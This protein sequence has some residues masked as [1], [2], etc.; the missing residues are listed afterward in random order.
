MDHPT[1]DYRTKALH[2]VGR[3]IIPALSGDYHAENLWALQDCEP[4]SFRFASLPDSNPA[5]QI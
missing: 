4:R 1:F 3:P 2:P 5:V